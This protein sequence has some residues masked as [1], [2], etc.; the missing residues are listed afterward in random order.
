VDDGARHFV[1]VVLGERRQA[2][3]AQRTAESG[4]ASLLK[5]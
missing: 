1:R 3:D 2:P 5:E 4:R